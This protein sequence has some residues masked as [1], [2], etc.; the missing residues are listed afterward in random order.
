M[1]D[2][3]IYWIELSDYDLE[4]A[5]A[6]LNTSRFLYVGFMCHQTIEKIFKAWFCQLKLENPPYS[7]NLA[8]LARKG[9]FFELLSEDQKGVVDIL[10]PLNVEARYPS[11]KDRLIKNLSRERCALILSQTKELQVWIKMRLSQK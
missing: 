6:M 8:Y 10:E 1:K 2:K 4:T 9:D 11:Y 3:V 5:E 7:H